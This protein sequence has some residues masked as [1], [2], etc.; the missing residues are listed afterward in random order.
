[1]G[2]Q[3]ILEIQHTDEPG[4]LQQG[5]AEDR[6]R[7][8][9]PEVRI[10]GKQVR[11]RGII[12]QHRLLRPEDVVEDRHGQFHA[13]HARM[14]EADRDRVTAGGGFRRD[15]QRVHMRQQQETTLRPRVLDRKR[16]Q[17][18]DQLLKDDLAR[19]RLGYFDHGGEVQVLDRR[20][21]GRRG[22]RHRRLLAEMRIGL[23][24][25]PH[26]ALGAPAAIAVP[27]IAQIG[28][29]DRLK[30]ARR[31]EPRG[32]FV[33]EALVLEEAVLARQPH[34][35]CIEAH[36]L[37]ITAVDA[38]DLGGVQRRWAREILG[39]VLRPQRQLLLV[40]DEHLTMLGPLVG[41]GHLV[42]RRSREGAIEMVLGDLEERRRGP[43]Q[44]VH[45]RRRRRG[46]VV[47]R[48]E[49]RLQFADPIL[50]GGQL[51][52]LLQVLIEPALIGPRLG[53]GGA[54]WCQAAQR[55]D[56]AELRHEAVND[57][58]K[59]RLAREGQAVLGL[60]L[61]LAERGSG[62]E[63]VCDQEGGAIRGKG[64][65]AGVLRRLEGASHQGATG[66][67]GP[68]PGHDV[69]PDN[70]VDARLEAGQPTLLHQ[71]EPE[72]TETEPRPVIAAV[73]PQDH[74]ELG[75]GQARSIAVPMLQ[76]EVH[77]AD[78]GK[79]KQ[80]PIREQGRRQ[81]PGEHV[82][83]RV[84]IRLGH[85]RQINKRLDRTAPDRLPHPLQCLPDVV[86]RRVWRPR[87][88]E[89]PEV[90]EAHL[91]SPIRLAQGRVDLHTQAGD[92][93]EV[94]EGRR[95]CRQRPS[96]ASSVLSN[97]RTRL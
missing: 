42:G 6:P 96:A 31:V 75:I 66:V 82:R 51:R 22:T 16:H 20:P 87:D 69:V 44:P 32:A 46:G 73:R 76:T 41:R 84:P 34:G 93:S 39:A 23:V 12:E 53:A 21:H 90:G 95:P 13:T 72:L 15:P 91:D 17:R 88:A 58:S 26:L 35:L 55:P 30:A 60:L 67:Q 43:G 52:I 74:D 19:H 40:G 8:R 62:S 80:M 61:D 89:V 50:P 1:V 2:G 77:H 64:E 10:G 11:G 83:G 3:T 33:G 97:A 27:G 85:Q 38:R 71:S 70:Q 4:L 48:V 81:E 14:A 36:G 57:G 25:L 45:L 78:E 5:Q 9:L 65:I 56:Q 7:I 59:P 24:E 79:S 28:V 92:G 68:R 86:V 29:G 54:V 18:V 49:A 63:E 47:G 94:H 37:E